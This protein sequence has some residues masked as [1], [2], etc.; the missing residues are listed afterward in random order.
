[1]TEQRL[2]LLIQTASS[3]RPSGYSRPGQQDIPDRYSGRLRDSKLMYGR[4]HVGISPTPNRDHGNARTHRSVT[5][6]KAIA[7]KKMSASIVHAS[8]SNQCDSSLRTPAITITTT[9]PLQAR[10]TQH[11]LCRLGKHNSRHHRAMAERLGG[12]EPGKQIRSA[13][14]G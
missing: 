10:Q 12:Q 8:E 2:K 3:A 6:N 11:L 5:M 9:S 14:R 7:D 13:I 4:P 1:M